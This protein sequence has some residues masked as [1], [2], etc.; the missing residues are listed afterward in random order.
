MN[1]YDYEFEGESNSNLA[2]KALRMLLEVAKRL[3]NSN[4]Q[5]AQAIVNQVDVIYKALNGYEETTEELNAKILRLESLVDTLKR[6][7]MDYDEA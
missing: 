5:A 4:S 2:I 6:T 7:G 3:R 1:H